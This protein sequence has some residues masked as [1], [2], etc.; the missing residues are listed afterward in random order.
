[1]GSLGLLRF[2]RMF[3]LLRLLRLLKIEEY[4]DTLENAL[5]MNLRILRVVF[6]LVGS[7]RARASRGS[8]QPSSGP[9]SA[10]LAAA[11][12]P[13]ARCDAILTLTLRA[14]N[15]SPPSPR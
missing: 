2:L 9:H 13:R 8:S 5:D 10:P 3:R 1:M 14:A 11:P 12:S 4:I 7:A 15:S 6:M